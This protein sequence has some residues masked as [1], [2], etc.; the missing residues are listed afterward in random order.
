MQI[1]VSVPHRGA[2]ASAES[3]RL[4][5]Q[6][7]ERFGYDSVWT[8]DHI[9][10]V[11]HSESLY[12]LGAEPV[13]IDGEDFSRNITPLYECITT[14]AYL[15][16][17]TERV[18]IGSA[19]CVLP[20]RNPVYNAR[21][22]SSL[23]ALSGGRLIFGVGAGWLREEAEAM[24][25]PWDNR[26][27]RTDEHIEVLQALWRSSGEYVS[28]QGRFYAFEEIA[29]EPRPVGP[30]PI[31][32]GGH[33]APA[34]RRAGR[35]G[36]GWISR[37]LPPDAQAAGMADVREAARAAGRDPESLLFFASADVRASAPSAEA[38][39]HLRSRLRGY[40]DAGVHHVLLNVAYGEIPELLERIEWASTD[41]LPEFR[42]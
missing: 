3:I 22:I 33:S 6:A 10:P 4:V 17:V 39:E 30:L 20:L 29:P 9:A 23:D 1:G 32:V 18:H 35:L 36:D 24:Q 15:A 40:A 21:Q 2:H 11:R 19:V 38:A 31:L 27:A 41:V 12:D 34:K 13:H 28:Y 26:G 42:E 7:A 5:A 14:M 16:A 25:M 37:R 8:V